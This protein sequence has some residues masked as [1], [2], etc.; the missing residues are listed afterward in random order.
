[1]E[2]VCGS[3]QAIFGKRCSW[4]VW[5]REGL[6]VGGHV[7]TLVLATYTPFPAS[8]YTNSIK[9]HH[10]FHTHMD[11]SLLLDANRISCSSLSD[12]ETA[13]WWHVSDNDNQQV[14]IINRQKAAAAR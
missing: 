8:N 6:I 3:C 5:I 4:L 1:M 9:N 10:F 7:E 14:K 11:M 2:G 12:K 13:W